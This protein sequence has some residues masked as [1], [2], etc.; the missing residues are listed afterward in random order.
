MKKAL[1]IAVA[2]LA[3]SGWLGIAPAQATLP[4]GLKASVGM[5]KTAYS[6]S[7]PLMTVVSI[8]N[9]ETGDLIAAKEHLD[10]PLYFYLRY[11]DPDGNVVYA[12]EALD[13]QHGIEGGPPRV[14]YDASG[15]PVQVAETTILNG[16]GN[17]DGAFVMN[18]TIPD[19]RALFDLTKS[20]RYKLQAFVPMETFSSITRTLQDGSTWSRLADS[21]DSGVLTSR[22]IYFV[23]QGNTPVG[24]NVEV[25][26]GNGVHLVFPQVDSGGDTTATA[27]GQPPTPPSG[28]RLGKPPVYYDVET[29]AQYAGDVV[30]CIHWEEGAFRN[31]N[32][33]RLLHWKKPAGWEDITIHDPSFDPY[34]DTPQIEPNP[35]RVHNVICGRTGNLSSPFMGGGGQPAPVHLRSFSATSDGSRVELAWETAAEVGD[36]GFN[37]LRRNRGGK[38][39]AAIN[40]GLIAAHGSDGGASYSFTDS[41]VM[42][43]TEY[44]Y[45]LEGVKNAGLKTRHGPLAVTVQGGAS[46]M[47]Q[48]PAGGGGLDGDQADDDSIVSSLFGDSGGGCTVSRA[49]STWGDA[50]GVLL[51]LFGPLVGLRVLGARRER[52]GRG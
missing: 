46:A 2:G 7:E 9:Q 27:S 39:F 15:N 26:A 34:P 13:E 31:E 21:Q 40:D 20:G 36:A 49:P 52:R 18:L 3:V 22:P 23:L 6:F 16:T 51:L 5:E 17:P 4:P 12:K 29:T 45:L 30:V 35:D 8:L 24:T 38:G 33:L 19:A 42:P 43:G 10:V 48:E 44:E 14:L 32:N 1:F 25:D 37:I 11:T 50:A 28:Y 47:Y 41:D